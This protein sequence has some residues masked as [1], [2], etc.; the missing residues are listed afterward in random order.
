MLLVVF[1]LFLFL[2]L[3][4]SI[5]KLVSLISK[6]ADA[7]QEAASVKAEAREGARILE[8]RRK[9]AEA[10]E[11]NVKPYRVA[12]VTHYEENILSLGEENPDY[13]SSKSELVDCG[14]IGERVYKYIFHPQSVELQPEPDNPNDPN[15]VKVIV[16]G[17][18]VGYVKAGS[19]AHIKKVLARDGIARIKC[20][21]GGGPYKRV[22]EDYD[23]ETEKETYTLEKDSSPLF[24]HLKITE[25]EA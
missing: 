16:D 17:E 11:G 6:K 4:A 10:A 1:I 25:K 3:V 23:D 19:C 20:E 21:I 12:G 8:E 13:D 18:H 14:L 22:D 24:V 7:E 2:L 9:Q 15:A 5:V